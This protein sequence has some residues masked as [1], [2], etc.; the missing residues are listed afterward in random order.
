MLLPYVGCTVKQLPAHLL[1]E[2][3][4]TA[5]AH[6]PANDV[7][8]ARGLY[9][10]QFI[11]MLTSKFWG[12][13]G[14]TLGVSFF[15]LPAGAGSRDDQLRNRIIDHMN[16][17]QCSVRFRWS[18]SGGEVRISRGRGGYWSYLG[19]DIL[20]VPA[21]QQ[22]MNLEGFTLNTPESE[23]RRVVR[24]ETG[25]T[26][27]FPHEHMR[28]AIVENINP[29]AAIAYFGQNQGWSPTEVQQQ[30]LTPLD[31]GSLRA[32]QT[33]TKSIMCYAL[34][35]EIMRD[36][37]PVPGGTDIDAIDRAFVNATYPL[38]AP[39]PPPPPAPPVSPP[40]PAAGRIV[41]DLAARSVTVPPGVEVK[42]Q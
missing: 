6:N 7:P 13:Q 17:W 41:I 16:A 36:G 40:P 1:V 29:A 37:R 27:G 24:H 38:P 3:A 12:S 35:G 15:D 34:P 26:L 9:G 2:A 10:V 19:T 32:A 18:Q 20:H 4:R 30:V 31:E 14:R 28:K 23:Y 21:G 11:A 33:D 25:H 39:P 5:V 8:A 22:T 42:T